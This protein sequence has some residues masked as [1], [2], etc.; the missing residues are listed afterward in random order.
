MADIHRIL[1]G[2][3]AQARRI[4]R[5]QALLGALGV[6]ASAYPHQ[7]DS[8]HR[9][10]TGTSC[11]WLL[12]DE[13]GLGKTVEAIMV[14]RALAAQYPRPLRVALLVPDDLV[15]QWEEELL[16]RGHVLALENGAGSLS[17]NLVIGLVRPSV[18]TKDR[19]IV[20][21]RLDLLLVDEFPRLT[22]QVRRELA[23]VAR[24]VPNVL[25]M[26]ATPQLHLPSS[27][28]EILS[29]LEPEA[30][31]AAR[32]EGR[33]ILDV[34]IDREA[35]ATAR[36]GSEL[37]DAAKRRLVGEC[38]GMYRRVVRSQ[39]SDHP[40]VLPQRVYQPMRLRPTDGDA[41]RYA[42]ARAYVAAARADR[43]D[44]RGDLLLQVAGRS[45]RSLRERLSTL[46]RGTNALQGAWSAVDRCVR[47][48]PGDA[49][50]DALVDH[51]R[52]VRARDPKA[53]IVV[54]AEDNPTTDYLRD[55][56]ERLADVQVATKRRSVGAEDGLEEQLAG[57][58][59]ALDPFVS[60]EATV[61][62]AA[63]I[64]RE[65]HNLQYAEELVFFALP[66]SPPAV[67]QWI[68][69]IDRI[70]AAHGPRARRITVTT[71]VVEGSPEARVLDVLEKSGVFASSE[72]FD[73]EEG[74]AIGS[75]IDAAAYGAAGASWNEA[76]GR[77]KSV[78]GK[79]DE[80]LK[81][82][83]FP[84]TPRTSAAAKRY[85]TMRKK[86]YAAP[87]LATAR[88]GE[89]IDWPHMREIAAEAMLE[90]AQEDHLEIR[91]H[92]DGRQ[93]F[94]SMWYRSRS[95]AMDGP[96]YGEL[97][98]SSPW[99]RQFHLTRRTRMDC[100]P[101][102]SVRHGDDRARRLRFFD[103]GDALHDCLVSAFERDAP[104]ASSAIEHVVE[105]P[106]GHP[107]LGWE[108]RRLLCAWAEV[109]FT[110]MLN[111]D[112][113]ALPKQHE[114][115][116][117]KP[118]AD[119]R[120]EALRRLETEQ[121]ADHRWLVDRC[122]PRLLYSTFVIEDEG[123][124]E[125]DAAAAIMMPSHDGHGMRQRGMLRSSV[126]PER[127]RTMR[128]EVRAALEKAAADLARRAAH[129][130]KLDAPS[131]RF[132]AEA[133]AAGLAAALAAEATVAAALDQ[134]FDYNQ[135]AARA[136]E[137]ARRLADAA[138]VLRSRRIVEADVGVEK[139]GIGEPRFM[140]LL[141]RA[142]LEDE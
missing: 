139:A 75:A 38:S 71:L 63:D 14:I 111:F 52:E 95:R 112:A 131:R 142:R 47:D 22:V 84:P 81:S 44:I 59:G 50:L 128:A 35:A 125:V 55:A 13:V 101:R 88:N 121:L 27:R 83:A 9:M 53:R 58:K 110:S 140:V 133:D 107:L 99:H 6:G 39:R 67:Q 12:A 72:V 16:S 28:A 29:I 77:A 134:K 89:P 17:G 4:D 37:H 69:R 93:R 87:F 70:G 43:L 3:H 33:G 122:P 135:A 42:T 104:R 54:V 129:V 127:M 64:A 18:L 78:G 21:D 26:S 82:T 92:R 23:A 138:W 41:G 24:K 46:N 124:V 73:D 120:A 66:W 15:A 118:E 136:A 85:E 103:H 114:G 30:E 86:P 8:V 19:A 5:D 116:T 76:V 56:L 51:V 91:V 60:G 61:L 62:V 57:L 25:L 94:K 132:A 11:R 130:L 31:R 49:R 137:L 126:S 141:P 68:G 106:I 117:S 10:V 80:W 100:P 1:L 45:P 90:L 97:D 105:L 2:I 108:G 65:G 96:V 123:L 40:D 98:P 102:P 109:D 32:A 48:Q 7:I 113:E 74:Q 119:V 115:E 79:R 20:P 34:L 36:Y